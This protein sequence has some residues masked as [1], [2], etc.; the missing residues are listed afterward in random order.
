MGTSAER[1]IV[2][3]IKEKLCYVS[4]NYA[5]EMDLHGKVETYELPDGQKIVLGC[6]RFRCPEALF[7]PSLLGQEVMG[8]HEATHHSITNCDMDLRKDMYANI[9]LSGGTTMFRNIEHRFLQDLTE[10]APPSIRIKVN[11]SPDRRFSVWTGGSVL[12][13]LTSFQNMWID[14]L[15]YEEVGSAIVHRKCF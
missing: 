12:A 3:E 11:A 9:V 4:M 6:E 8:I 14:S 5:K 10:M 13:S 15:E 2:R 1:E 7:Q